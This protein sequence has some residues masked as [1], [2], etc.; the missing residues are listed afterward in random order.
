MRV[1]IGGLAA[2]TACFLMSANQK[3]I[4][5][6]KWRC[7]SFHDPFAGGGA[8]PLE[9][10]RLGLESHASDLNPVETERTEGKDLQSMT[11]EVGNAH[12]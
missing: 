9:A 11:Q 1:R 7:R 5:N 6:P 12:T 10:Q 2:A 4:A 3:Q 8:L